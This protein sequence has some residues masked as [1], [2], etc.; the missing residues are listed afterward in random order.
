MRTRRDKINGD[1]RKEEGEDLVT[2]DRL[3]Q[4]GEKQRRCQS[5]KTIVETYLQSEDS[6]FHQKGGVVEIQSI[7]TADDGGYL[8]KLEGM[9]G[10]MGQL[11]R[12]RDE[13]PSVLGSCYTFEMKDGKSQTI[14][15]RPKSFAQITWSIVSTVVLLLII[16]SSLWVVVTSGSALSQYIADR[17]TPWENIRAAALLMTMQCIGVSS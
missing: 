2:E 12:C 7:K 3:A 14:R 11:K 4:E 1:P 5:I 6:A 15:F 16:T 10:S 8:I 9:S 17:E 13:V